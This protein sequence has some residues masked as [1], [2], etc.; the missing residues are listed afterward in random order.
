MSECGACAAL[1]AQV[2]DLQTR[3]SILRGDVQFTVA[4]IDAE[5][6]KQTMSRSKLVVDVR[7]RLAFALEG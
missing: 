3:L 6:K 2:A 7:D 1:A 4:Q 5:A